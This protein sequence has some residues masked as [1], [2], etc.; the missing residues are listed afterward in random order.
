MHGVDS[1]RVIQLFPR[2]RSEHVEQDDA[3]FEMC[4]IY[5]T[6]FFPNVI[7]WGLGVID[8]VTPICEFFMVYSRRV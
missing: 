3:E 1:W 5:R 6:S 2:A 4:S 7:Y 8:Q